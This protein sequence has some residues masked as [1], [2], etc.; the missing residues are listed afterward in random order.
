MERATEFEPATVGLGRPDLASAVAQAWIGERIDVR[1][2]PPKI[3]R[4]NISASVRVR[5]MDS[6]FAPVNVAPFLTQQVAGL[7][8]RVIGTQ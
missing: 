5:A 2:L 4:S 1:Y 8:I 6:T 3:P 7:P